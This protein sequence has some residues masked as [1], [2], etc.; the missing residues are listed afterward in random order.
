MVLLSLF[1]ALLPA[2]AVSAAA[3]KAPPAAEPAPAAS[4]VDVSA[5]KDKLV[6]LHDGKGHYVAVVPSGDTYEHLYYGDGKRFFAQ[7]VSGGSRAGTT[8]WERVFWEPRVDAAWKGS[9]GFRDGK[10]SVQCGSRATEFKALPAEEQAAMLKTATFAQPLWTREAY[11]LARDSKGNYY[12]VDR[13][14]EPEGNKAFRLLVGPRGSLKP[15]KMT[16]VVSDSRGD[17]FSTKKGELRLVLDLVHPVWVSGKAETP[18]V[19]LP[20]DENRVLVYTDLGV[21]TGERLGTPCDD[22][23]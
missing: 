1:C 11:A 8:Q 16:N 22:L 21:Y 2:G 14:R 18:L 19:R 15:M 20:L 12:F 10:Y 6:V 13:L 7:R 4:A 3:K 5:V 9:I 23:L 17:I